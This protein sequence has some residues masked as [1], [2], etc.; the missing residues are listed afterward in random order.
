MKGLSE[1]IRLFRDSM[2]SIKTNV[3]SLKIDDDYKIEIL[4]VYIHKI[5]ETI[6]AA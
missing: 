1:N 4:I 5:H 2:N 6:I 3:Y